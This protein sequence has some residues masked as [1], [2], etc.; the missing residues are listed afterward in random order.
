[1][2]QITQQEL[3]S[4]LEAMDAARFHRA[5]T[6]LGNNDTASEVRRLAE[7]GLSEQ[8]DQ[9]FKLII[10]SRH[11]FTL[12][13]ASSDNSAAHEVKR[14]VE[15]FSEQFNELG[16]A[17]SDD[18]TVAEA[19]LAV[20]ERSQQLYTGGKR[21][22]AV[23]EKN[24]QNS[25]QVI[26]RF[27]RREKQGTFTFNPH[28]HVKIWIS[29]NKDVF[30]NA[31]NQL[32]LVRMRANCPGDEITLVYDSRMLSEASLLDL[33]KFCSTNGIAAIDVLSIQPI[34]QKNEDEVKLLDIY[35]D[36]I[37]HLGKGG[38]LAQASDVLRVLRVVLAMGV[39]SDLDVDVVTR[40]L[41]KA[42]RVFGS[43][44]ASTQNPN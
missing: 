12:A 34:C 32:R 2:P 36:Q 8:R 5:L 18:A 39:Y 41:P 33:S 42:I 37:N 7:V 22:A 30:M 21:G 27:F 4:I 13:T 35:A 23:P 6:N 9:L 10:S 20:E 11:I 14:F 19:W 1:M 15:A 43:P 24:L 17:V 28:R 44:D 29:S 26:Q 25:A 3:I 38:N 40:H 16:I 31:E